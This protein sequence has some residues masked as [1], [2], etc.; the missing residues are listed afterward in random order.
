MRGRSA[1]LSA[2]ARLKPSRLKAR[3]W[4]GASRKRIRELVEE[5]YRGLL[6]AAATGRVEKWAG[7]LGVKVRA[8]Y[9][10][11][12]KTKW[13]GCSHKKATIRLNTELAKRAPEFLDYVVLHEVAHLVEPHHGPRFQRLMDKH[14]P[15]WRQIRDE[16]NRLPIPH[17]EWG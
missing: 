7:V 15:N 5:W 2:R 3:A 11:Q 17:G 10:Q 4:P 12:M 6:R 16:L 9:V 14:L 13:G 8:V 1:K